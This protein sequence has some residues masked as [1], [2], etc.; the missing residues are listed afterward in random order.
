MKYTLFVEE[1]E[2][3]SNPFKMEYEFHAEHIDEVLMYLTQF[4]KGA[5]FVSLDHKTLDAVPLEEDGEDSVE[6]TYDFPF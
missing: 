5:G 2:H 4:L 3:Y 1:S 6:G